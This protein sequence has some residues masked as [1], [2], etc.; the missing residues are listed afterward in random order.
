MREHNEICG[1]CKYHQPESIGDF[2]CDNPDGKYFGDYTEY[3][4]HCPDWEERMLKND[5]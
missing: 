4:D 1:T 5:R 3:G 2:V